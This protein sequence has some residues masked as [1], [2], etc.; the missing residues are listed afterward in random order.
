LRDLKRHQR[1]HTGD[2]RYSCDWPGCDYRS[3]D[4]ANLA[5]HKRTHT[6]EKPYKCDW[7]GCEASFADGSH[8]RRHQKKHENQVAKL[9]KTGSKNKKLHLPKNSV[10]KIR[11]QPGRKA[12]SGG[13]PLEVILDVAGDEMAHNEDNGS[14]QLKFKSDHKND[15]TENKMQLQNVNMQDYND[16]N[17]QK[18]RSNNNII[19]ESIALSNNN[20]LNDNYISVTTLTNVEV[21]PSNSPHDDRLTLERS[22]EDNDTIQRELRTGIII[23]NNN[24]QLEESVDSEHIVIRSME[25]LSIENFQCASNDYE[26]VHLVVSENSPFLGINSVIQINSSNRDK[27]CPPRV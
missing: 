7:A 26:R 16:K 17:K 25:P 11:Q 27:E 4:V 2:K 22:G 9:T 14:N 6:G 8:L 21:V 3:T 24:Q 1:A 15:Q 5:K 10:I 18:E 19:N 12:K 23:S 20:T 13:I